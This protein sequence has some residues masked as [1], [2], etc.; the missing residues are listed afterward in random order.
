MI[1]GVCYVAEGDV[2]ISVLVDGEE[3]DI[4]FSDLY[5]Y[6]SDATADKEE[7]GVAIVQG[8]YVV[9]IALVSGRQGGAVY[10]WDSTQKKIVHV[11]EGSFGVSPLIF[12]N[13][14][15][16]LRCVSQ[17]AV[18]PHFVLTRSK[19]GVKDADADFEVVRCSIPCDVNDFDGDF[20]KI[21]LIGDSNGLAILLN[22]VEYR[23]VMN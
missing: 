9:G 6:W 8:N 22:G 18:A 23:I 21:S 17:W 14:V 4:Y 19:F 12:D 5:P 1:E 2:L 10:V 7:G 20:E 11:S 15:Y 3:C 13:M 16:A